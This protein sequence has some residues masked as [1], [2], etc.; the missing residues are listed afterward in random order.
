[1]PV[2]ECTFVA[3]PRSSA[4]WALLVAGL[5]PF[6][7]VRADNFGS[8][9][10]DAKNDAIVAEMIYRGT[11]AHHEFSLQWGACRQRE[12]GAV[13]E[14]EAQVIDSQWNDR[15]RHE[16][17]RTARLSLAEMPCRPARVTLR[18]APRFYYTIFIPAEDF[19]LRHPVGCGPGSS[20]RRGGSMCIP[21]AV[22]PS[23]P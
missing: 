23:E 7:S 4:K 2:A 1:M 3:A 13:Q 16:Y 19:H 14:I 5:G 20:P 6:A 22:P 15:A 8:V 21:D 17:R 11:N 18:T 9:H 10:Y 12:N